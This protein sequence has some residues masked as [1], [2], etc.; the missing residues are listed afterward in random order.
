MERHFSSVLYVERIAPPL[1]LLLLY[2]LF[3]WNCLSI[4]ARLRISL[5]LCSHSHIIQDFILLPNHSL[6]ARSRTSLQGR[7]FHKSEPLFWLASQKGVHC[8]LDRFLLLDVVWFRHSAGTF[9]MLKSRCG[10]SSLNTHLTLRRFSCYRFMA[11]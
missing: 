9:S 6:A 2:V 8:R 11:F 5:N 10:A 3:R 1:C 7:S 4:S